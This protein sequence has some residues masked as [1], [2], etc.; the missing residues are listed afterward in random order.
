MII[1]YVNAHKRKI[2]ELTLDELLSLFN[3][4][5]LDSASCYAF[6]NQNEAYAKLL[7]LE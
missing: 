4:G 5:C 1:Y 3:D 2:T 6:L 7:T